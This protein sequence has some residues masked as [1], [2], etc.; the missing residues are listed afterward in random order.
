MIPS[1]FLAKAIQAA[2]ESGH[3]WPE[4]AACEA[5]LESNWGESRLARF[6]NNL[7]GRKAGKTW[8]GETLSIKTWEDLN[9][10]GE[11]QPEEIVDARWA[12]FNSW[13]ECFRDRMA[14]LIALAPKFP[15]YAEALD[16]KD[17]ES[18]GVHVS[19]TWATDPNRADKV[20]AIHR[21]HFHDTQ[22]A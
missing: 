14:V 9:R 1:D 17:G 2:Q 12:K 8:A 19:H 21:K 7:F 11:R 5:A 6:G 18:F 20:L 13:D 22:P 4:Y 16:A 3:V 15:D 10:D